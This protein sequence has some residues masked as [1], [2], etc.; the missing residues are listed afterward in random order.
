MVSGYRP[1]LTPLPFRGGV[2]G[3]AWG[4]AS[5]PLLERR[6]TVASEYHPQF[7][8]T[9]HGISVQN[10]VW[11]LFQL[12]AEERVTRAPLRR[13]PSGLGGNTYLLAAV[14]IHTLGCWL[15]VDATAVKGI[16][17]MLYVTR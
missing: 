8:K 6:G 15:A 10:T 9:F 7:V 14:D 2:G 4:E 16:E 11:V 13:C 3:M 5:I 12:V 17:A 1:P